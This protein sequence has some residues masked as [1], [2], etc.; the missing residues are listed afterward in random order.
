M[1]TDGKSSDCRPLS[2]LDG[3]FDIF[4]VEL[5]HHIYSFFDIGSLG[6]MAQMNACGVLSECASNDTVWEELV[7]RRFGIHAKISRSTAHGGSTWKEAFRTL[8]YCN[9]APKSRHTSTRK[10]IFAKGGGG[11]HC[12]PVSAWV[13]LS[14]TANCQTRRHPMSKGLFPTNYSSSNRFVEFHV[15]LQN[16]KTS[17]GSIAVDLMGST[18]DLMGSCG[19]QSLC[20]W[21]RILFKSGQDDA[22]LPDQ[23]VHNEIELKPFEF[24]IVAMTFQC[25][26]DIFETDVLARAVALR[27]PVLE[28]DS[29]VTAVFLPECDVW[30][31]Y[32]ELPGGFLTLND[33]TSLIKG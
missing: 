16:V 11:K 28:P 15:C 31:Y 8:S 7:H 22:M 4:P 23:S 19:R 9:R 12:D 32:D 20:G 29:V 14:H 2:T 17:K 10:A 27:V 5:I 18:L 30:K 24:C 33:Q 1:V 13:L 21:P 25:G 6:K 26:T 3:T